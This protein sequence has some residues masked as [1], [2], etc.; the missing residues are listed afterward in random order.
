MVAV[1]FRVEQSRILAGGKVGFFKRKTGFRQAGVAMEKT[2][3]LILQV[4]Q[5]IVVAGLHCFRGQVN[6]R[7][8][9]KN[10][11]LVRARTTA[12]GQ[13]AVNVYT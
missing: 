10:I 6:E 3:I 12:W 2:E 11:E 13:R 4:V 7:F 5:H 8:K 9:P 1:T